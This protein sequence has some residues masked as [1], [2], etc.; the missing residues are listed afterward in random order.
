MMKV[1]MQSSCGKLSR[2]WLLETAVHLLTWTVSL[3][4]PASPSLVEELTHIQFMPWEIKAAHPVLR[5]CMTAERGFQP[6]MRQHTVV[7]QAI[8]VE[9]SGHANSH[10]AFTVVRRKPQSRV[11]A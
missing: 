8:L 10:H 6:R 5:M 4:C 11:V 9:Q 1:S 2:H 7:Y 3:W